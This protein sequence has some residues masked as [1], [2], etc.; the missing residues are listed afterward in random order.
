MMKCYNIRWGLYLSLALTV[1]SLLSK[2]EYIGFDKLDQIIKYILFSFSYVLSCWFIHHFFIFHPFKGANNRTTA[3]IS[4]VVTTIVMLLI[5]FIVLSL[6]IKSFLIDIAPFN[7]IINVLINLSRAIFISVFTYILIYNIQTNIK[8]QKSK[9]ENELLKQV[10]LRAQLLSLQQ[11]I[12][13]HFLFNSLSTLKT[14]APDQKTK[15]YIVQLANVYR[16][17]LNF[18][19]NHLASVKDELAFMQSYLYILQERF[20]AALQIS[21]DIPNHYLTYFIPPLSLQLLVENAVKHN[22]SSPE[23]PLYIRIYNSSVADALIIENSYQPKQSVEESTGKGLKNI[24]DRYQLLANEQI[25][26]FKGDDLFTVVLPL[27]SV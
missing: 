10:H 27:L 16:Y 7:G 22:I 9:L 23:R 15:T 21:I 19:E 1:M 12:S 2:M 5:N 3:I 14:I 17:L 24:E 20:E 25:G 4:N 18:N 26:V 13:P 11:Q 8:F 6:H